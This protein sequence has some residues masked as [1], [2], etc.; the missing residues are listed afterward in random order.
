MLQSLSRN[1]WTV[2][3]RGVF[4]IIF[5]LLALFAPGLTLVALVLFFGVYALVDGIT[6]VFTSFRTQEHNRHWWLHLI[7]GA[8]GI[9]A[10][11]LVLIWPGIATLTLLMVIAAWAFL[12]GITQ[13][14]AAFRLRHEIKNEWF[15]GLSGVLSVV[16]GAYIFLF[17]SGGALAIAWL[18]GLY[19]L[20]FGGFFI[21][22]SLRLRSESED[23]TSHQTPQATA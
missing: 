21:A 6:A 17:P 2:F 5:G 19:A 20:V 4:S 14:V 18:I 16:F 7:E 10:G 13:I 23:K 12:T 11:I 22:L 1:W 3:L 8:V 9:L 15:L